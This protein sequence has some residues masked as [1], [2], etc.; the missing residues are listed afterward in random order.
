[1]PC[2]EN[3]ETD[4]N[5]EDHG[6]NKGYTNVSVKD[7]FKAICGICGENDHKSYVSPFS[8]HRKINYLACDKFLAMSPFERR[9]ILDDKGLCH[10]CLTA[11]AKKGHDHC[12]DTYICRHSSHDPK[13]EGYHVL[14][15]KKHKST[16]ENGKV[17]KKFK[18][19]FIQKFQKDLPSICQ[20][21][22]IAGQFGA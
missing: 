7:E 12:H 22:Q 9:K 8:G 4:E 6:W 11:N 2:E 15:C 18:N 21:I 17:L 19:E 14:V 5:A 20:N 10:Q 1:M 13:V 16:P 3:P